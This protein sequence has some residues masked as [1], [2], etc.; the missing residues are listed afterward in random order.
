MPNRLLP[1]SLLCVGACVAG[2]IGYHR[3]FET[4]LEK[5][6]VGGTEVSG[7]KRDE[8]RGTRPDK[9]NRLRS[10][11]VRSDRSHAAMIESWRIVRDFSADEI[12]QALADLPPNHDE[13][14]TGGLLTAMLYYRWAE[15]D[16]QAAL[17]STIQRD[18]ATTVFG[19]AMTAW[20]NRDPEAAYRWAKSKPELAGKATLY[21]RIVARALSNDTPAGT[22]DKVST[23]DDAIRRAV[24]NVLAGKMS[25]TPEGRAAFLAELAKRGP[26]HLT[27]GKNQL[28]SAW[29]RDDPKGALEGMTGLGL[30]PFEAAVKR[31]AILSSWARLDPA[32]ALAW[33]AGKPDAMPLEKRT[34]IFTTWANEDPAAAFE[35]FDTLGSEPG[36]GEAVMA[37][38]LLAHGHATLN[39]SAGSGPW[40]E[41]NRSNL[42]TC[43]RRWVAQAPAAAAIWQDGLDPDLRKELQP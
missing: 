29:G 10:L 18:D 38:L 40:I 35:H 8:H 39:P 30:D 14:T 15:I 28:L 7:G 13:N 20:M 42:Q 25:A 33:M 36:F 32:L 24:S 12:R 26:D 16:P 43:Y 21:T 37:K 23:E 17:E 1:F 3:G 27:T 34:Q 31:E 22:L 2:F 19:A 5:P 6:M 41:R 9:M 11:R 4:A